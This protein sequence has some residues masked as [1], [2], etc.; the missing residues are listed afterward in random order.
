[1]SALLKKFLTEETV[2]LEEKNDVEVEGTVE[3]DTTENTESSIDPELEKDDEEVPEG[4]LSASVEE[5]YTPLT[6][7]QI[8]ELVGNLPFPD[9]RLDLS[10][11]K[12]RITQVWFKDLEDASNTCKAIACVIRLDNG[13]ETSGVAHVLDARNFV[14]ELGE[15]YAFQKAFADLITICAYLQMERG[16]RAAAD[17]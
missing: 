1:M 17:E 3:T 5:H 6:Q 7:D 4:E 11:I 8:S 16:H 14:R 15:H 10:I 13:F 9:Q 12:S 2:S